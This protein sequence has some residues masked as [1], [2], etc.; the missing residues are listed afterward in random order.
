[1]HHTSLPYQDFPSIFQTLQLVHAWSC[2]HFD[3]LF[4]I[5]IK[6]YLHFCKFDYKDQKTLT[7]SKVLGNTGNILTGLPFVLSLRLFFL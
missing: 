3:N 2:N 5:S 4:D 1:M 7:F 6:C